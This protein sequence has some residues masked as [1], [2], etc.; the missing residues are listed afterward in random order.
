MANETTAERLQRKCERFG[1]SNRRDPPSYDVL[2]VPS[3]LDNVA[4]DK[5]WEGRLGKKPWEYQ[6]TAVIPHCA[7][8]DLLRLC[9]AFLRAQS[10][11]VYVVVVDT[12]TPERLMPNLLCQRD[13]DVEIHCCHPHGTKYSAGRVAMAMD[14]GQSVVQTPYMLAVHSDCLVTNRELVNSWIDTQQPCIGYRSI[15]RDYC[16]FWKSMVSHT[17]TLLD[18]REIDK[19]NV[20]WGIRRLRANNEDRWPAVETEARSDTE[21]LMNQMLIDAGIT[22]QIIGDETWDQVERDGNRVHLRS[23]TAAA[24]HNRLPPR[25]RDELRETIIELTDL[26]E[27]YGF[28]IADD[29]IQRL[30]SLSEFSTKAIVQPDTSAAISPE[31]FK[32]IE[33]AKPEVVKA[34]PRIEDMPVQAGDTPT[35]TVIAPF[36]QEFPTMLVSLMKQT[37]RGWRFL[38]YHDGPVDAKWLRQID[39][40]RDSRTNVTAT[41]VR[42]NDMGHSLREAGINQLRKGYVGDWVAITNGHDYY[43]PKFLEVVKRHIEMPENA[44]AVA[45]YCDMAHDYWDYANIRTILAKGEIDCGCIVVRRDIVC[46]LGFPWRQHSADWEWIKAIIDKYGRDKIVKIDKMLFVHN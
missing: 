23:Y 11:P 37:H 4:R 15:P 32:A 44:E 6:V 17:L 30:L 27:S 28:P 38:L 7:T 36:F 20:T 29:S 45:F 42:H 13:I 26:A 25:F 2:A 39:A 33:A 46:D 34:L 43:A 40:V 22:P 10:V 9:I 5:P 3:S 18:M 12:G 24:I 19:H 21:V 14:V 35:F 16:D 8:P 31:T 1:S 41:D